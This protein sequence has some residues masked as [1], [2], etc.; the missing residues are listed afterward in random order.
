MCRC[1]GLQFPK[2]APGFTADV[3]SLQDL[4]DAVHSQAPLQLRSSCML[5]CSCTSSA[6]SKIWPQVDQLVCLATLMDK[7]A[8][9]CCRH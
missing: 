8:A 6:R 4:W 9:D 2:E 5:L 1:P 3:N 7:N